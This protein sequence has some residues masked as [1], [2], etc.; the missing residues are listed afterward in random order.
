MFEYGLCRLEGTN[1]RTNRADLHHQPYSNR[2][3][4]HA[5]RQTNRMIA[6]PALHTDSIPFVSFDDHAVEAT[7]PS[8]G[9][10]ATYEFC[11]TQ[12]FP[13]RASR[14]AN[15]PRALHL[16]TCDCCGSTLSHVDLELVMP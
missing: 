14:I 9:K 16:Y 7:C 4:R 8:C 15:L 3:P 10:Y 1:G 13:E 5:D 2:Y 12:T 11:G 6:Q